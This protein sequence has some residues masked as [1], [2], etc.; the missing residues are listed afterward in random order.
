MEQVDLE[1]RKSEESEKSVENN[2][3]NV[4]SVVLVDLDKKEDYKKLLH[5]EEQNAVV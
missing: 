1:E 2:P 3:H 4:N 5:N